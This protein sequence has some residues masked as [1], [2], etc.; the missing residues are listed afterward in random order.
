MTENWL[1]RRDREVDEW[2]IHQ[3]TFTPIGA[4]RDLHTAHPK[5]EEGK[6]SGTAN[7]SGPPSSGTS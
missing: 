1:E 7:G 3:E 6:G 5:L 4:D 2:L